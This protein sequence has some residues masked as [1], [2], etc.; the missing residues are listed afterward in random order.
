MKKALSFLAALTCLLFIFSGCEHDDIADTEK[1]ASSHETGFKHTYISKKDLAQY[2]KVLEILNKIDEERNKAQLT[3]SVYNED[4]DFYVNTD[5]ILRIDKGSYHSLTFSIYRLPDSGKTENLVLSSVPNGDYSAQLY[6]YNLS[7]VEK[8]YLI[9]G[10]PTLFKNLVT[11]TP[12]PLFKS[13]SVAAKITQVWY[14]ELVII[15][16]SHI[17]NG[18]STHNGS[19]ISSW[20]GCHADRKPQLLVLTRS[21]LI[22]DGDNGWVT[23]GNYSGLG[24]GNGGYYSGGTYNPNIPPYDPDK[25]DAIITFPLLTIPT[26]EQNFYNNDLTPT[27]RATMTSAA[28]VDVRIPMVEQLKLNN[29]SGASKDV[30]KFVLD[31]LY[32]N[33]T[34]E[35]AI[36][37]LN[38]AKSNV[39]AAQDI[40]DYLDEN[41]FSEESLE[42]VSEI[43]DSIKNNP[44]NYSSIKPFLIEKEINYS[45]LDQCSASVLNAIKNNSDIDICKIFAKLDANGSTYNTTVKSASIASGSPANTVVNSPYNYTVTLN[46]DFPFSNATKLGRATL[47][48]HELIHAYF[49][50]IFDDYHNGVPQ[51]SSAYNDFP[52]LFQK[53]VDKTYPGSSIQA[54]HE[55]M[56][57]QYVNVMASALQEYQTGTPVTEGAAPQQIYTDLAWGSLQEAPIFNTL[58]P[59][60]NNNRSRIIARYNSELIGYPTQ[61]ASPVGNTC[62]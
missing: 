18:V 51:N 36:D 47:L 54:H 6:T 14:T 19:N 26:A 22:D 45:Q 3:K 55:E 35:M 49:M 21:L 33:I 29:F 41:G 39:E 20:G 60:E 50:S 31:N 10:K 16:C 58:Y 13:S 52:T 38:L 28:N 57:N 23:G 2:P 8:D 17:T 30:A 5:S 12:L 56:A 34:K 11:R 27:Q 9:D 62:N 32:S 53:F 59:N 37:I 44:W 40:C 15:G 24:S 43:V 42:F 46:S 48:I 1:N 4:Y 25:D 61:G 7:E